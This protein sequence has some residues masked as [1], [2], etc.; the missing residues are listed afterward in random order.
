MRRFLITETEPCDNGLVR[1]V[2]KRKKRG[3]P[4]MDVGLKR[5]LLGLYLKLSARRRKVEEGMTW[6]TER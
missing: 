5:I 6:R 2:V 3:W 1:R 4:D